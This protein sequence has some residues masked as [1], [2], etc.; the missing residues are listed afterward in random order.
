MSRA[1]QPVGV[2]S[3]HAACRVSILDAIEWTQSSEPLTS[4][5]VPTKASRTWQFRQSIRHEYSRVVT[6]APISEYCTP[7]GTV[8]NRSRTPDS[9]DR[10]LLGLRNTRSGALAKGRT[11]SAPTIDTA[12][13]LLLADVWPSLCPRQAGYPTLRVVEL[14]HSKR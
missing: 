5:L 10:S 4:T 2:A 12:P 14:G 1:E 3:L 7:E 6:I 9:S 13:P 8:I 11:F